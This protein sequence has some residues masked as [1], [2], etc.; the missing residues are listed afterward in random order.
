MGT[1]KRVAVPRPNDFA[2]WMDA[3]KLSCSDVMEMLHDHG[4]VVTRQAV[5]HWREGVNAP[6]RPAMR[7]LA[8]LTKGA[9]TFESW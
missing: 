2:R 9:V 5:F 7:A 3:K 1:P 4:I 8:T 6:R